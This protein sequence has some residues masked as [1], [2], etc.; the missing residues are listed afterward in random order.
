MR[1]LVATSALATVAVA[2]GLGSFVAVRV[3]AFDPPVVVDITVPPQMSVAP[4]TPPVIPLPAGGGIAVATDVDGTVA[5][6]HGDDVAPI[7]SVAK[8][9]TALVV[10]SAKPLPP[11][12]DGPSLTMTRED[13]ALY[14]QAV[15]ENGSAIAVRDGEVLSEREMLL[16][17][18]LPSAN[19]I[20]ETLAGW[21]A[22]DRASFI[23]QLNGEAMS[24]GMGHTHFDDPSGF[25][26][27][28]TSTPADLLLLAKRAIADPTLAAIVGTQSSTLSDGTQLR[29]LDVLLD[30][31]GWLGIKTGWTPRAGGCLLFSARRSFAAAAAP[32]T[33]FGAVLGQPPSSPDDPQHPELGGAFRVARQAAGAALDAYTAVDASSLRPAV[34]GRLTTAWDDSTALRLGW[35]VSAVQVTVRLGTS[36]QLA[37]LGSRPR[38]S[39][40]AGQQTGVVIA[41]L[42]GRALATWTVVTDAAVGVPSWWWKLWH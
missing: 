3:A 6:F 2:A 41:T 13:V 39:I 32:V 33:V 15:A 5:A 1:R 35:V 34:S 19:N 30:S 11:G 12:H 4:G 22:G 14:R 9:M 40:S 26:A 18:M 37:A 29:N 27:A 24:L 36:A 25:S 20:A 28:T 31:P 38:P 23:A 8:T 21:V 7:G 16:A 17:L 42:H 10:L